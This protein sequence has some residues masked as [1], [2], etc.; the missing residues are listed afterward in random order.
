MS[1]CWLKFVNKMK[2]YRKGLVYSLIFQKIYLP[3]HISTRGSNIFIYSS[4]FWLDKNDKQLHVS[5]FSGLYFSCSAIILCMICLIKLCNTLY[6]PPMLF[7]NFPLLEQNFYPQFFT[8]FINS[9]PPPF[10][11]LPDKHVSRKGPV[12]LVILQR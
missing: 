12:Y 4:G 7:R 2:G 6:F 8:D 5:H 1:L 11:N 10:K 3:S 9:K